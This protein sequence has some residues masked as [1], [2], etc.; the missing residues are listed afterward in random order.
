[1]SIY[2]FIYSAVADNA[3]VWFFSIFSTATKLKCQVLLS[4]SFYQDGGKFQTGKLHF[5]EKEREIVY[6]HH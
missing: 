4:Q 6:S 3:T 5:L 1:M 2:L